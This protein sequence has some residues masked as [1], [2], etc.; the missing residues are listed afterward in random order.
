MNNDKKLN[1]LAIASIS[2]GLA[3][4][5]TTAADEDIQEEARICFGNVDAG[6][7]A[8]NKILDKAMTM[9]NKQ[10]LHSIRSILAQEDILTKKT[11]KVL[12]IGEAR[13]Q[14]EEAL[15]NTKDSERITLAARYGEGMPDEDVLGFYEDLVDLDII[16][17]EEDP[18]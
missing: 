12:S 14:I 2:N 5:L 8:F 3:E 11:N 17:D 10:K 9:V 16:N 15:K 1:R 13:K 4:S 6:V 7:E 18:S